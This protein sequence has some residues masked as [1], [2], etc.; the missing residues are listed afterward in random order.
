MVVRVMRT[1]SGR[2]PS[3]WP[4]HIYHRKSNSYFPLKYNPPL[5]AEQ[6]SRG[7]DGPRPTL[8]PCPATA[9]SVS[10]RPPPACGPRVGT[11]GR[12]GAKAGD[13]RGRSE[14]GRSR[15]SGR[16]CETKPRDDAGFG[17]ACAGGGRTALP[18]SARPLSNGGWRGCGGR[19][20]AVGLDGPH[21]RRPE[22]APRRRAGPQGRLHRCLQ[23]WSRRWGGSGGWASRVPA[24]G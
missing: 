14:C 11:F 8:S 6:A 2:R 15:E 21:G 22:V 7:I 12:D 19:A 9:L 20:V 4:F 16:G 24:G 13:L 18:G 1:Q 5:E 10:G 23:A 3:R 17:G